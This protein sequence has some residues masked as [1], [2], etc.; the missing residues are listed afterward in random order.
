[1]RRLRRCAAVAV[2]VLIVGLSVSIDVTPSVA[3]PV[4]APACETTG[5]DEASAAPMA[6]RCGKRVEVLAR[7]SESSQTSNNTNASFADGPASNVTPT[8][9]HHLVGVLDV[10]H[11]QIRLYVDGDLLVESPMDAAW[12]PWQANGSF[13]VGRAS[14]PGST[15]FSTE[16]SVAFTHGRACSTRARSRNL[17]AL[18][19]I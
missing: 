14:G 13:A 16:L 5:P 1:M 10:P 11:R 12:Q 9:W 17:F 2:I 15:C 8:S 19:H 3:A 18:N 7:R 6:K 4:A